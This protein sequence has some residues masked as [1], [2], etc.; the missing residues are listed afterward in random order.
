MSMPMKIIWSVAVILIALGFIINRA[1]VAARTSE[2]SES[3]G[4]ARHGP[5]VVS[6]TSYLILVVAVLTIGIVIVGW[7]LS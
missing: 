4:G 5:R 2:L 6:L 1:K 3:L 7:F